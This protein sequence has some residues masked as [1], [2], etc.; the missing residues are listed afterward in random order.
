VHELERLREIEHGLAV[1]TRSEASGQEHEG[2]PEKLARCLED[3]LDRRL[4]RRMSPA[5]HGEETTFEFF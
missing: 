4:E 5:A 3:V 2:R 1:V